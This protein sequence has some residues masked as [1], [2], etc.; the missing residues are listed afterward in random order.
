[1]ELFIK[2]DEYILEVSNNSNVIRI[3]KA[4][5]SPFYRTYETNLSV[6]DLIDELLTINNNIIIS[7]SIYEVL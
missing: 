4:D 6:E 5:L 7:N 2:I 3:G 1:M